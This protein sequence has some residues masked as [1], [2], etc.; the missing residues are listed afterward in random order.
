MVGKLKNLRVEIDAN[1]EVF[2]PGE[3]NTWSCCHRRGRV[4]EMQQNQRHNG[5]VLL[6]SLDEKS[7]FEK[8]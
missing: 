2:N 7:I 6:L 5:R 3:K 8:R 4:N 1:R